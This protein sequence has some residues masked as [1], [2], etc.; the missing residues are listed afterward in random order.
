MM[1]DSN[2]LP[3]PQQSAWCATSEPLTFFSLMTV[4]LFSWLVRSCQSCRC[5]P[6]SQWATPGRG[7]SNWSSS[8]TVMYIYSMEMYRLVGRIDCIVYNPF[9][10]HLLPP[11]N[12]YRIPYKSQSVPHPSSPICTSLIAGTFGQHHSPCRQHWELQAVCITALNPQYISSQYCP[13]GLTPR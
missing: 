3:R 13:Q 12:M 8:Y 1:P 10:H 7:S 4:Y 5:P 6:G 9:R 2:P 11:K